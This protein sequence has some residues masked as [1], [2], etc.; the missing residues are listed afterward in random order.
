MCESGHYDKIYSVTK[1]ILISVPDCS[2]SCS[3]TTNESNVFPSNI[4]V[5]L[6]PS[7]SFFR[8]SKHVG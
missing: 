4:L 7:N 2:I 8:V 6:Q 3:D 1:I 5:D